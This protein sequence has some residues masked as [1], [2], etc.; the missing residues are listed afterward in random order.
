MISAGANV[1]YVIVVIAS[2]PANFGLACWRTLDDVDPVRWYG[3]PEGTWPALLHA[4]CTCNCM[5][6]FSV[7]N[8]ISRVCRRFQSSPCP[9]PEYKRHAWQFRA[10]V[11]RTLAC[12]L[13]T[14]GQTD[15]QTD[16][17]TP[18]QLQ[19]YLFRYSCLY[20]LLEGDNKYFPDDPQ[21]PQD[22]TFY[23]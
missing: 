19:L 16:R 7:K 18:G 2:L 14:T 15:R 6:V 8:M 11:L 1:S 9:S 4:V 3:G 23:Q 5:S 10:C 12:Q 21:E 17:Q 13:V 20:K 22:N